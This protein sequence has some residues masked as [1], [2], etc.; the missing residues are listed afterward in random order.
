M[1]LIL[2]GVVAAAIMGSTIV[3]QHEPLNRPPLDVELNV[4]RTGGGVA[5]ESVQVY[6][7]QYYKYKHIVH[8][9]FDYSCGSAALTT[10]LQFHLGLAI[11]EQDAMKGMLEHGEQDKIIAR[12][13]F[14]LLD[15]KR[16]VATLDRPLSGDEARATSG[17][18]PPAAIH[19]RA[20]FRRALLCA[21]RPV[22]VRRARR[23]SPP[24]RSCLTA[25][26]FLRRSRTAVTV[27]GDRLPFVDLLTRRT[28]GPSVIACLLKALIIASDVGTKTGA[29][30]AFARCW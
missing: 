14:S 18:L 6:P 25:P 7:Y 9:A 3:S 22:R 11:T 16:Y 29:I 13:G 30:G 15:M 28:N 1:L 5:P 21:P 2:L 17:T 24:R 26:S 23:Y 20:R 4:A 12:R 8:Q 27:P 10:V 19:V